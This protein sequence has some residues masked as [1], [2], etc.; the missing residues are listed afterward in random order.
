MK[1]IN[2]LETQALSTETKTMN[3]QT[4]EYFRN[5]YGSYQNLCEQAN[6][7]LATLRA[8]LQEYHDN[9]CKGGSQRK[10]IMKLLQ[11][12]IKKLEHMKEEC[13]QE[14]EKEPKTMQEIENQAVKLTQIN[15]RH[16]N[17][18][19]SV[20][21]SETAKALRTSRDK[22]INKAYLNAAAK[23]LTIKAKAIN[24]F[25]SVKPIHSAYCVML[26]YNS[27]AVGM[28]LNYASP[29]CVEALLNEPEKVLEL[30][31]GNARK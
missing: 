6:E 5:V 13:K 28:A 26:D 4:K 8:E 12:D 25:L 24:E 14:F 19:S 18:N 3:E 1:A 17:G 20:N 2:T 31:Y 30:I 16:F 22:L 10:R 29:F 15:W 21:V 7:R 9:N 23:H 27:P 11:E